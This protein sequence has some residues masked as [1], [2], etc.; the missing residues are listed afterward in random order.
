MT[1]LATALSRYLALR[2]SLGFKYRSEEGRLRHFVAF[3][4]ARKATRI[5]TALVLKFIAVRKVGAKT[6]H[7]FLSAVRGFARHLNGD[8]P[9]TEVPPFGIGPIV[10]R[11]P[12]PYIYKDGE[13]QRIMDVA[14]SSRE[15]R[16]QPFL[17]DTY[18]C[19]VGTYAAT[20]MRLSEAL[21]LRLQDVDLK[22]GI[23]TVHGSKFGK[24]RLLPIQSST[25][26][27]LSTYARL[28]A[29]EFPERFDGIFFPS[30]SNTQIDRSQFEQNFRRFCRSA[31]V[32]KTNGMP[33][34]PHDLRHTFAVN[35]LLRWYRAGEDVM[36]LLPAL[37][38]YLGHVKVVSTYW[39][40]TFTPELGAAAVQL[41]NAARQGW[42]L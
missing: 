16:R 36:A 12:L 1:S 18:R 2:R 42:R 38:T 22:S 25:I 20:G 30:G 40:F 10:P 41:A 39:Y 34:R 31:G 28:R 8:D 35:T 13:I 17:A 6:T 37:S 4:R 19:L 23:I 29:E 3:L 14:D 33:P 27:E 7:C 9:K 24:S 5:R 26:R 15:W 32:V 11:R 21:S